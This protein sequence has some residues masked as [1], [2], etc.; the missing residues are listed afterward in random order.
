[1]S[2]DT[3]MTI[4]GSGH[5][6]GLSARLVICGIDAGKHIVQGDGSVVFTFGG[7]PGGIITPAYIIANPSLGTDHDVTFVV[8]DGTANHTVTIPVL[9]GLDY[10]AKGQLIRPL[11][12]QVMQDGPGAGLGKSRRAV[13]A[14]F[15]VRDLFA[16]EAGTDFANMYSVDVTT[17]GGLT[18]E[19]AIAAD[20]PYTG[21]QV[22][23][24]DDVVGFDGRV[25]WQSVGP[26][27]L[28]IG[29]VGVFFEGGS[30]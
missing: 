30:R 3:T 26:S 4:Y 29:A 6:V 23:L 9:V 27:P 22:H 20:A 13:W 16:M 7:D 1:M 14:S 10:T 2:A 21:V 24:L 28:V 18:P 17:D 5:L 8:F 25:A 15:L 11:A 19:L 12:E